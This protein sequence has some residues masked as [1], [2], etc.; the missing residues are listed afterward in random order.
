ME[1][2]ESSWIRNHFKPKLGEIEKKTWQNLLGNDF[3]VLNLRA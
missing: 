1:I 2:I 3:L